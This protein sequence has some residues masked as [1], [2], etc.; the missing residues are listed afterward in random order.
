M[1]NN[2]FPLNVTE[3]KDGTFT[4]EWDSEH[5]ATLI[6]NDWTE[7]QF[8]A[9]IELG[10]TEWKLEEEDRA[11][12]TEF[13]VEEFEDNFDEL[14]ERVENGETLTIVHSDGKRVLMMPADQL[15]NV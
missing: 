6:M 15:P 9:V 4:L 11:W 2:D 3:N 8:H 10:L 5:P 14:F 13:A 7:E 12:R 1:T